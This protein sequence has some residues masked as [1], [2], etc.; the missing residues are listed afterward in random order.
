MSVWI[1]LCLRG[2]KVVIAEFCCFD[3]SA[4]VLGVVDQEIERRRDMK[5]HRHPWLLKP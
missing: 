1:M 2:L 4:V 5:D 3:V